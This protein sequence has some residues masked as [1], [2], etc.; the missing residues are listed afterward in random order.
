MRYITTVVKFKVPAIFFVIGVMLG[1]APS[2]A[3]AQAGGDSASSKSPKS[4]QHYHYKINDQQR[5]GTA[6]QLF[7]G[8]PAIVWARPA[9]QVPPGRCLGLAPLL[10]PNLSLLG[11]GGTRPFVSG[12]PVGTVVYPYYTVRGPRDFL[13]SN[14][15]PLGP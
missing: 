6:S 13:L 1:F 7:P 11:L 12:P 8:T 3:L 5:C 10:D 9:P 4:K 2:W 14:P 15:P